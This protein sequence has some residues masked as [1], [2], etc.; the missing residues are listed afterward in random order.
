MWIRVLFWFLVF[1]SVVVVLRFLAPSP[2][3]PPP[4]TKT[5]SL[6][7]TNDALI[8]W[9]PPG[10]IIG[11]GEPYQYLPRYTLDGFQS[12]LAPFQNV[13]VWTSHSWYKE[14]SMRT[15]WGL[16]EVLA[17]HPNIG[18]VLV[19]GPGFS[20]VKYRSCDMVY[21]RTKDIIQVMDLYDA[22]KYH[23]QKMPSTVTQTYEIRFNCHSLPV[24]GYTIHEPFAMGLIHPDD[25]DRF[26]R[27]INGTEN[28]I[29]D[30][31]EVFR[32]HPVFGSDSIEAGIRFRESVKPQ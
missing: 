29:H 1:G 4:T 13:L 18:R 9:P 27:Y 8:P 22:S 21:V 20:G 10:S 23:K 15:M 6:S 7:C 2:P 11:G 30:L 12:Q 31:L 16:A 17:V 14:P 5:P 25:F 19:Y 26:E 3:P 24:G 28:P 32:S